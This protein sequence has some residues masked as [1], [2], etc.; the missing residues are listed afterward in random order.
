MEA[1]IQARLDAVEE[2]INSEDRFNYVRDALKAL[3]KM[4]LDKLIIAVCSFRLIAALVSRLISY[5]FSLP[6]QKRKKASRLDRLLNGYP[7][8]LTCGT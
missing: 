3:N 2:L 4:D 7:K 5:S 8:C 6:L 1:S